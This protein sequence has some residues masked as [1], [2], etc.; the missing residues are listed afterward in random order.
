MPC[1]MI[2]EGLDFQVEV[3]IDARGAWTSAVALGQ[4]YKLQ[5]C[6]VATLR[7][8]IQGAACRRFPADVTMTFTL[9]LFP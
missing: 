7:R 2:T 8:A 4:S 6:F 5:Q 1:A 9:H 3:T